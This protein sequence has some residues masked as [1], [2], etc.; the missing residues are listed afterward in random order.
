MKK[1]KFILFLSIFLVTNTVL[2]QITIKGK[3]LNIEG[4]GIPGV[5]ITIKGTTIGTQTDFNGNFVLKNIDKQAILIAIFMGYNTKEVQVNNR[6]ELNI[7]FIKKESELDTV[8][9]SNNSVS[10]KNYWLGAKIGYNFIGNTDDNFFVGSASIALNMLENLD[11][12]HY[13]GVIGN[14]GNFKFD[15]STDSSEDIKKLV[16]SINGLSVGLG[17]TR[18]WSVQ[19]SYFRWFSRTGVRLTTFDEVG[20]DKE[21]LNLAQSVTNTG[22]EYELTRFKNKGSLTISVG[23][24]LLMFDKRV[25][26]K[27]FDESKSSLVTFDLTAILPISEK[28]GVFVNGTFAKKT[29]AAYILGIIFNP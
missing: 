29:S 9:I 2:G 18:E 25:Y 4:D 12:G 5:T 1:I 3:V 28:M 17:Y 15:K 6:S 24:S 20:V 19:N 13:F 22:I 26:N 23:T 16:Q 10:M 11:K 14:I 27:I 21:T 8:V 7:I